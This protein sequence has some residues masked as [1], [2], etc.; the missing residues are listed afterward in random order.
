MQQII[1]QLDPI[2]FLNSVKI[3]IFYKRNLSK[4]SSIV[5]ILDN[6]YKP[7]EISLNSSSVRSI[8]FFKN[9]GEKDV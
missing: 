8:L 3:R 1:L 2:D 7:F 6:S 4:L 9:L 5:S